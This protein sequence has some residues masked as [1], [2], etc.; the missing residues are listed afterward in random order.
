MSTLSQL[1]LQYLQYLAKYP[2]LTKSVTGACLGGLNEIVASIIAGDVQEV[3]LFDSIK[4][5]NLITPKVIGLFIYGFCMS[6]PISHYMYG[7][8]NQLYAGPPSTAKK[9]AQILTSLCTVTPTISAVYVLWIGLLNTYRPG[10]AG[11]IGGE[12]D[13]IL[14]IIKASLKNSFGTMYKTSF[15]TS[16]LSL[17]IAQK[18]FPPELW[19]VFFSL[20]SFCVGTFQNTKIKRRNLALKRAAAEEE[21]KQK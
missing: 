10:K 3:T 9:V 15:V 17:I 13:R 14:A 8:I 16:G 4:V 20:V 2:L 11:S 19:V 21:K 5:K 6:T 12:I 1:N 18:Y 7:I